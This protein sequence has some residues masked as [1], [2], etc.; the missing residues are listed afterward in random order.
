EDPA[1]E[2]GEFAVRGGIF[3]IFP[4]GEEQPVRLELVGDTIESLRRYYPAPQRSVAPI[5][6]I[7]AVPFRDTLTSAP[8]LGAPAGTPLEL[9]SPELD[10]YATLFDYLAHARGTRMIV[11]E[12]D[13]IDAD[14]ARVFD[15]LEHS[16]QEAF[17]REHIP[18]PSEL[19]VE[20]SAIEPRLAQAT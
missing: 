7:P 8:R 3:D 19:F 20:W 18:A 6:Q 4:A 11:A 17:H 14:A 1:D 13:E 9:G 16:Y 10:R 15:Q 2:H 12:R 5:G